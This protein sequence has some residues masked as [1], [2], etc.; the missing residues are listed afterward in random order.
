MIFINNL[1]I[2][3]KCF[4][5]SFGLGGVNDAIRAEVWM[6]LFGFYSFSS[7]SRYLN[8]IIMPICNMHKFWHV[9]EKN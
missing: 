8:C 3:C 7:T 4:M 1:T 2:P 9:M 6:F 5:I